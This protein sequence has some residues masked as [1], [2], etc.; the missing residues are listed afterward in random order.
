M[1]TDTGKE[2]GL[3][4]RSR[5]LRVE[6]NG[7]FE[8]IE[9]HLSHPNNKPTTGETKPEPAKPID[10]INSNLKDV[11]CSLENT[12]QLFTKEFVDRI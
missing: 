7:L 11:L 10:E 8:F 12:R 2:E 9:N 3:I 5:K 4:E 6:A 1:E